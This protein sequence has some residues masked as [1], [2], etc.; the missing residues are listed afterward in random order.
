MAE[1]KKNEQKCRLFQLPSF[2]HES[3]SVDLDILVLVH[4]IMKYNHRGASVRV[5]FFSLD[6]LW[7]SHSHNASDSEDIR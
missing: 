2:S 4:L 6:G 5:V 7:Y 3:Q 1:I